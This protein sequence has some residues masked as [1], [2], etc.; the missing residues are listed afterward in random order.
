M[1][2]DYTVVLGSVF[3]KRKGKRETKH[4][5]KMETKIWVM[6]AAS[7]GATEAGRGKEPQKEH[8]QTSDFWLPELWE[9]NF[10]LFQVTKFVVIC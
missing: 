9:N 8:A 2:F 4:Q 6:A 3:K 10:L 1:I 5:V 7:Q